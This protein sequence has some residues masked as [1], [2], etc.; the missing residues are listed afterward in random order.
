VGNTLRALG[1]TD[2]TGDLL[3][4]L[5]LSRT[6]RGADKAELVTRVIPELEKKLEV[7]IQ[8]SKLPRK[9]FTARPRIAMDLSHQGH[10]LSIL[11]TLVYGDP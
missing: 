9:S 3:E 6:F 10:T 11:P 1:E 4:R 2:T 8:T 7:A 5:P